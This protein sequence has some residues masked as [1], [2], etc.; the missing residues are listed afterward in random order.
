KLSEQRAKLQIQLGDLQT[1]LAKKY[2]PVAGQI[3]DLP[4][5]QKQL[6]DNAALVAWLDLTAS[7]NAADRTGDHWAWLLRQKGKPL[8]IKLKG[9][10]EKGAW[11]DADEQLRH[12]VWQLLADF[13]A[14]WRDEAR[15]L[16]QQRLA[17]LAKH[18]GP[19]NGL[20]A[21]EHL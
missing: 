17:P 12:Q 13:Q 15:R 7:P 16:Y 4:R 5:I 20:P 11:T 10:G 9:T 2:G 3:Y 19:G 1:V 18:L 14:E 6:P 8:W 21:V